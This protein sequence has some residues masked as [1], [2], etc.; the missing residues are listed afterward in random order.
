MCKPWSRSNSTKRRRREATGTGRLLE[1]E[2]ADEANRITP[3][4]TLDWVEAHQYRAV[5]VEN[6]AEMAWRW[7]QF[8]NWV[9][10]M[11]GLGYHPPQLISANSAFFGASCHRNRLYVVFTRADETPPSLELA[12][13]ARCE[14]C[15]YVGGARQVFRN[16]RVCG[17]WD[18]QYDYRCAN[19]DDVVTPTWGTAGDVLDLDRP[20]PTV[21]SR[22]RRLAQASLTRLREGMRRFGPG[23]DWVVGYFN[24]GTWRPL[25]APLGT[26]TCRDHHFVV[27]NPDSNDVRNAR[28]RYLHS[29]ELAAAMGFPGDYPWPERDEDKRT[30]VGNAVTPPLATELLS[31]LCDQLR[32]TPQRNQGPELVAA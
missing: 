5:V 12:P 28:L 6:V 24:P 1:I 3:W 20:W 21:R 27:R 19:C 10:A 18:A 8:D 14:R 23:A 25:D 30:M 15:E 22:A 2:A 4:A 17:N 16:G 26:I 7:G 29:D 11:R 31:Q 9:R 32:G 13:T